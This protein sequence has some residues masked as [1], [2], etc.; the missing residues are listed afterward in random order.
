M[1]NLI[2]R[3]FVVIATAVTIL[4]L[5]SDSTFAMTGEQ[6]GCIS[7][8]KE[9]GCTIDNICGIDGRRWVC[10]FF[11]AKTGDELYTLEGTF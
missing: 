3:V 11:D 5:N 7:W 10:I 1:N 9:E 4:S 6:G 8:S 2:K